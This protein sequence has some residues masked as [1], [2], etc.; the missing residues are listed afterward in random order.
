RAG[1]AC[2]HLSIEHLHGLRTLAETGLYASALALLR[3]LYESYI[4]GAWILK[5]ADGEQA[6]SA[7]NA[8][9][10]PK[11]GRMV[12]AISTLVPGFELLE[13]THSTVWGPLN[14]FTHGG[15]TQIKARVR[16]SEIGSTISSGHVAV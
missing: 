2:L 5:C 9:R 6:S 1:L 11:V 8:D 16:G 4:R 10:F 13:D 3:P 12:E 15:A 14:D 7:I